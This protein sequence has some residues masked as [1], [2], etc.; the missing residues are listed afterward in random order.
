MEICKIKMPTFIKISCATGTAP[1]ALWG[2]KQYE[3][4]NHSSRI[5]TASLGNVYNKLANFEKSC[6]LIVMPNNKKD[7]FFHN[8]NCFGILATINDT[9]LPDNTTYPGNKVKA[10]VVLT[11]QDYYPFG[12]TMP[13]RNFNLASNVYRYGFNCQEMDDE[14]SGKGN[15]NTAMFWEYDCRLGRRWNV[16]PKPNP[17]FSSYSAFANNPIWYNDVLGDTAKYGSFWD[18]VRVGLTRVASRKFNEQFKAYKDSRTSYTYKLKSDSPS[19]QIAKP[20]Y[21]KDLTTDEYLKGE[22]NNYNIDYSVGGS[23]NT[24]GIFFPG[25]IHE[26]GGRKHET[27]KRN[28]EFTKDNPHRVV[29]INL[30]RRIPGEP[31][32]LDAENVPDE[33]TLINRKNGS[34]ISGPVKLGNPITYTDV[35]SKTTTIT[36]PTSENIKIRVETDAANGRTAN[37]PTTLEDTSWKIKYW[38][39]KGI[40]IKIPYPI[41]K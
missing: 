13:G 25:G 8:Q 2:A 40:H 31:I 7:G 36:I 3:L 34:T 37:Q 10:P 4:T 9:W 19:L 28:Y 26:T 35:N 41:I 16:D 21:G 33:F 30:K 5:L 29:N 14:V 24:F 20:D 18:R 11:W 27:V 1:L 39:Y 17:S 15:T 23:G 32:E 38:K 12:M 6:L 22:W